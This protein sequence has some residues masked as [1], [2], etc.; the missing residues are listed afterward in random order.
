VSYAKIDELEQV[1]GKS[2]AM[3]VYNY[4][5]SKNESKI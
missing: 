5:N 2:K 3:K 4:F 1:I